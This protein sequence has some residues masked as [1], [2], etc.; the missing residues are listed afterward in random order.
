MVARTA[1]VWIRKV[2]RLV[3]QVKYEVKQELQ[4]EELRQSLKENKNLTDISESTSPQ[5]PPSQEKTPDPK[6]SNDNT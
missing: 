5:S 1:A 2:R 3:A 4:A 6:G